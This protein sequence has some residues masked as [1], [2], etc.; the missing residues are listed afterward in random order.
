MYVTVHG[1]IHALLRGHNPY[2]LTF[3]NPYDAVHTAMYYGPGMVVDGRIDY[4]FAYLPL[5][6]FG[7]LPGYLL[8]DLRYSSILAI[9]ATAWIARHLA[10]DRLGRLT[11]L[12]IVMASLPAFVVYHSWVE[13]VIGFAGYI[14]SV[15]WKVSTLS[16]STSRR[17]VPEFCSF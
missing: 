11:A 14:P 2:A 1:S 8:G 12:C 4:G 16:A 6:L 15:Y 13:P 9:A 10:R 7:E 5:M 3:P 17:A